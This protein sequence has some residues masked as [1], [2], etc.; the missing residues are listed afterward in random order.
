MTARE[1]AVTWVLLLAGF[2]GAWSLASVTLP[3][4]AYVLPPPT[5]VLGHV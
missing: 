3:V 1:T 5:A 4:P 2:F